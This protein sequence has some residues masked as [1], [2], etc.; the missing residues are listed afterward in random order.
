[1]MFRFDALV[2][3]TFIGM[4]VALGLGG[5]VLMR[6]PDDA[7]AEARK[8]RFAAATF[9]GLLMLFAFVAALY[10]DQGREQGAGKDIFDKSLSAMTALAGGIVGYL[11]GSRR[12]G[13]GT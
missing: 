10:Y 8:V 3:L 13:T 4:L 7:D 5:L 2:Y 11:F 1:M 12:S 6:I 9:T